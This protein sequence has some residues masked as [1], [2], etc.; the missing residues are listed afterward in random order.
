VDDYE[1]GDVR[2]I[3]TL[4][5]DNMITHVFYVRDTKDMTNEENILKMH[6][7]TYIFPTMGERR[8]VVIQ[9][10]I[11]FFSFMLSFSKLPYSKDFTVRIQL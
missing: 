4:N 5:D 2:R 8:K 3:L 9:S 7:Y 10:S 1:I 11:K 6:R